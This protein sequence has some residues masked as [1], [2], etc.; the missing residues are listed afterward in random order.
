[1]LQTR[2][3][4]EAASQHPHE[5]LED[6]F[7]CGRL[8]QEWEIGTPAFGTW[9]AD[10]APL[11][12]ALDRHDEARALAREEVER[13][14]AFGAPAPLGASLRALGL[15]EEGDSGIELLEESVAQLEE[16]PAR[17]HPPPPFLGLSPPIRPPGA[18]PQAP[19]PR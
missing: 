16:S 4:I 5:A 17:P 15:I 2:A 9:R 7:A 13:C 18:R 8:E 10:A 6:L 3:R 14:R 12:A 19:R 1:Y 11:L